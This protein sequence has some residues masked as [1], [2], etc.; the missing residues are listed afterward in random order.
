MA[1]AN[2]SLGVPKNTEPKNVTKC[3]K[4][5]KLEKIPCPDVLF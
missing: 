2:G 3:E 5:S 1:L 4:T